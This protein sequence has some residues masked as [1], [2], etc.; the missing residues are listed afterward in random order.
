MP[1]MNTA[2]GV[3]FHGVPKS[4]KL[5]SFSLGYGPMPPPTVSWNRK[6]QLRKVVWFS[7]VIINSG[8]DT[9]D[10]SCTKRDTS[11]C[12]RQRHRSCWIWLLDISAVIIR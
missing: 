5:D 3:I 4:I 10:L 7:I 11:K 2:D 9:A 1:S 8:V 6:L 12:P